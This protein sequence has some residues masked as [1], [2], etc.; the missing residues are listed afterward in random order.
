MLR[1]VC[2]FYESQNDEVNQDGIEEMQYQIASMKIHWS[3]RLMQVGNQAPNEISNWNVHP[4][5]RLS[6]EEAQLPIENPGISRNIDLIIPAQ[7][8]IR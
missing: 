2:G 6:K 1:W 4:I 3:D 7:E 8:I 5:V